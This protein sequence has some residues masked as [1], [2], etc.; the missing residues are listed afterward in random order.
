LTLFL[1]RRIEPPGTG[2]WK[3][4]RTRRLESLRYV[5][6][7]PKSAVSQVSKPAGVESSTA[8]RSVE[9]S[10]DLEVGDTAGLEACATWRFEVIDT[11]VGIARE[12]QA[13]IF[14]PF[15]QAEA[16][17]SWAGQDLA[18]RSPSANSN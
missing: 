5:A 16:G 18:W 17:V 3:D 11:G 9:R 2:I 8:P 4:A 7:T 13:Q 15:Q 10:A 1:H 12:A 14:E 6:Q